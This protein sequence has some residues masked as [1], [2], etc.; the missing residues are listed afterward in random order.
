MEL[1]TTWKTLLKR[2]KDSLNLQ[3]LILAI[4]ALALFIFCVVPFLSLFE[5]ILFSGVDGQFSFAAFHDAFAST[6]TL[7]AIG[8]TIVVSSLVTAGSLLVG[9]PMAW[10]LTRSDLPWAGR[11]RSWLSLPFAIPPYVGAIAWIF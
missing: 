3:F 11:F 1:V 5:K 2:I 7:Q 4:A 8:N 6:A 10:L 9:V